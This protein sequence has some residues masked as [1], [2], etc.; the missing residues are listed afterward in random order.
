M[1]EFTY[2]LWDYVITVKLL[3]VYRTDNIFWPLYESLSSSDP[4]R[5]V[6]EFEASLWYFNGLYELHKKHGKILSSS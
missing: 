6:S 1:T 2:V 4:I 5:W 3:W